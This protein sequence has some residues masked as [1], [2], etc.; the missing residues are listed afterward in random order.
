MDFIM[1]W[2]STK[3]NMPNTSEDVL[4]L[5]NEEEPS[6]AYYGKGRLDSD[7]MKETEM[8]RC[9]IGGYIY[10]DFLVTHFMY[11]PKLKKK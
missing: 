5:L 1:E 3:E 11:I 6:L 2:I 9:S 7:K 4:I 8:W 10:P